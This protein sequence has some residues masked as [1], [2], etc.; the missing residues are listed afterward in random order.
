MWNVRSAAASAA[1]VEFRGAR[2][3]FVEAL[4]IGTGSGP[5][6]SMVGEE[7]IGG[8]SVPL[9]QMSTHSSKPG[10][11]LRYP[12][13]SYGSATPRERTSSQSHIAFTKIPM[14]KRAPSD[15]NS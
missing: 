4:A 15:G 12:D 13:A 6:R 8:G 3:G 11:P 10:P 14:L 9:C 7:G 2:E 1:R 5:G